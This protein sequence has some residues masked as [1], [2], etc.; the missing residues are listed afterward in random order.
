MPTRM[1]ILNPV[2]S[3]HLGVEI[4]LLFKDEKLGL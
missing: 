3:C 2:E 1:K 4:P